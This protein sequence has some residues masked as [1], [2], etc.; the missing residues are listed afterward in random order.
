MQA[1]QFP[2]HESYS[3]VERA[4]RARGLFTSFQPLGRH[5]RHKLV[6]ASD[7]GDWGIGGVSFWITHIERR[8]Y[9]GTWVPHVY[10]VPKSVGVVD[11]V[12]SAITAAV[13]H[14]A[15][16]YYTVDAAVVAQYGLHEVPFSEFSALVALPDSP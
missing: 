4:V 7:G 11:V 8:W 2:E 1:S 16:N 15:R 12:A 6:C 13:A 9:I 5:H 3:E 10:S 14:D